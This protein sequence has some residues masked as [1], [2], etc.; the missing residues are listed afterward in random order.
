MLTMT[1]KGMLLPLLAWPCADLS[2]ASGSVS[3]WENIRRNW[4]R[5][6]GERRSRNWSLSGFQDEQRAV[7]GERRRMK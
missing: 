4:R 3:R 5:S 2:S 6:G 1:S 7:M